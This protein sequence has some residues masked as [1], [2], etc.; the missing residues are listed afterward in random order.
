[1]TKP[2][3]IFFVF[4]KLLQWREAL[5]LDRGLDEAKVLRLDI[6]SLCWKRMVARMLR[7]VA[8]EWQRVGGHL[9]H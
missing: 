7:S 6:S 4:A 2:I 9:Q 3:S 1:M 8:K 5:L